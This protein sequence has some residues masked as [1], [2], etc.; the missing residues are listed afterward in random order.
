MRKII[1][2]SLSGL[3]CAQAGAMSK[4]PVEVPE[5]IPSPNSIV[6]FIAIGDM[7]TGKT[8]QYQVSAAMEQVCAQ[9]GCDFAL[10]L[11]DNIYETGVDSTEDEQWMSKFEKPY[12]NLEFP[13]FM[14]LGNHDNSHFGG[15][16]LDNFKGEN[17]VEYHYKENRFSDKWNMPARYYHFTAPIDAPK[18]LVDF[19]SLDSNPL[20]ALGDANIE[21]W[22]QPYKKKQAQWVQAELANSFGQWKVAFAH[23][24]LI[25][26]GRHSNAGIADGVPLLGIVWK[27]FLEKNVCDKIDLLI[28]G[29]DHDLQHLKPI[30]SC[31]KTEFIVS[32]G[33]AKSRSFTDPDRN[34]S[35]WQQDDTKGFFWIELKEGQMIIQSW[36]VNDEGASAKAYETIKQ[37]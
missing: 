3:L 24:P 9:Q 28:T 16:G 21:Y 25:S 34:A 22:Q 7:G 17:Q 8:G 33:G 37:K 20:A 5:P 10:G 35:F 12:E 13:F 2:I 1:T 4:P 14:T 19:Y 18:P 29:H 26:N 23:H 30:E 27:N 31:G 6:R 36:T 15:E 32:G 11:G